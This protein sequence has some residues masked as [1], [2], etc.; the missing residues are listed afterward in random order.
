MSRMQVV[1]WEDIFPGGR[2]QQQKHTVG[3]SFMSVFRRS[4]EIS[5]PASQGPITLTWK[6][7]RYESPQM[8][9]MKKQTET[10]RIHGDP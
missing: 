1:L 4:Q 3:I 6:Y 7:R 5:I 9:A 2:L 8:H 10:G